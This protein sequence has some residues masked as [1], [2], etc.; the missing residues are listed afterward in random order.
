MDF[1][2]KCCKNETSYGKISLRSHFFKGTHFLKESF[3]FNQGGNVY[4][5]RN[6]CD[7]FCLLLRL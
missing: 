7:A 4:G 3:N 2:K 5:K 6:D 1:T